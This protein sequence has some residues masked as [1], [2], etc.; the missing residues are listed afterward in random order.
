MLSLF[1]DQLA[2]SDMRAIGEGF[3][4]LYGRLDEH[5][6]AADRDRAVKGRLYGSIGM[7]AGLAAAIAVL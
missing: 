7:L 5:M 1:G 4:F 3:A 6:Q 2:S